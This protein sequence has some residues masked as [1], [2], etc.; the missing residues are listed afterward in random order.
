MSDG[1]SENILL[2]KNH[3][4]EIRVWG[5][6]THCA[7]TKMLCQRPNICIALSSPR[8]MF[9]KFLSKVIPLPL[10]LGKIKIDLLKIRWYRCFRQN[11]EK[12]DQGSVFINEWRSNI[13][14]FDS[15]DWEMGLSTKILMHL[16]DFS[17]CQIKIW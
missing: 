15:S 10:S 8:G 13:H 3:F 7:S 16:Q 9:E 14:Q 17:L 1:N 12:V 2:I 11:L 4:M 5:S 6:K